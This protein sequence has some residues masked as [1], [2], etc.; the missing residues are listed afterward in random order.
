[1]PTCQKK[2]Y[3][4]RLLY[5][6]KP[7]TLV[8]QTSKFK[9]CTEVCKSMECSKRTGF[10]Y[11]KLIRTCINC[12][13]ICG[14]H[15]WECRP[16]CR[17]GPATLPAP[18]ALAWKLDSAYDQ[19]LV[20]YLVL[21]LCLCTLLF[22]LLLTWIYV[23]KR[24]EEVTCRAGTITCHKKGDD[25]KECLMEAGSVGSGSSSSQ[26]PEPVETCGFCFPEQSPA[27]QES[28]ADHRAY[29]LGA[30]EETAV[31]AT[32]MCCPGIVGTTPA[33]EDGHFQII[34]SPSQEKMQ[35]T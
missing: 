25:P 15:P 5:K 34:C 17:S 13:T 24:G 32:G 20:V 9:S 33:P 22:S 21:G 27:V 7:C 26:T 2:E 29:H 35:M 8:C 30:R 11:D 31:T 1:M 14:Q 28:L 18:A 23:R 16:F 4:D 10:Y 6:C 3:W 19:Q 12:T